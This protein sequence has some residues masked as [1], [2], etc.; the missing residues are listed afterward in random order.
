MQREVF[1]V[2]VGR[3]EQPEGELREHEARLVPR[4]ILAVGKESQRVRDRG[5]A[6][7][8]VAQRM[9]QPHRLAQ[10]FLRQACDPGPLGWLEA[11]PLD[12]SRVHAD[13]PTV[14]A[15]HDERALLAEACDGHIRH[16][17]L[18]L[19][20]HL[21]AQ[22]LVL[23]RI[24]EVAAEAADD[25]ERELQDVGGRSGVLRSKPPARH[26]KQGR[27]LLGAGEGY[28][29]ILCLIAHQGC[30]TCHIPKDLLDLRLG[31]R[32]G[33][34]AIPSQRLQVRRQEL[35]R[36]DAVTS[37]RGEQI[38]GIGGARLKARTD[39]AAD[40]GAVRQQVVEVILDRLTAQL[41]V[42]SHGQ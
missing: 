10:V 5:S 18:E 40:L 3:R 23:D 42:R 24:G 38:K 35:Y 1:A 17:Q 33:I 30:G 13:P 32:R 21:R 11:F 14:E 16:R 29:E 34:D 4:A 36:A 20:Q 6:V 2:A 31:E 22:P 28:A 25:A 7:R 15:R 8:L 9:R 19:A 27:L 12:L 37:N 26:V 41:P 39:A